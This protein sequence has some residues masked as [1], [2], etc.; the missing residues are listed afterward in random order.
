[1]FGA[2]FAKE[3]IQNFLSVW[4]GRLIVIMGP[5]YWILGA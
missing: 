5:Q 4:A 2:P 1:M 3:E